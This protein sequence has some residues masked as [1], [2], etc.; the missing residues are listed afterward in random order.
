MIKSFF[1]LVTFVQFF[2]H[3]TFFMYGLYL[4]ILEEVEGVMIDV[5]MN[6]GT[7]LVKLV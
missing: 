1:P 6:S 3:S 2:Q 7:K 4:S 5:M